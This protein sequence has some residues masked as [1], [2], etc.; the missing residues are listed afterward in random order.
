[1]K[2]KVL[3]NVDTLSAKKQI[4]ST[5]VSVGY[6]FV[7]ANTYDDIKFKCEL[8]KDNIIIYIHELDYIIYEEEMAYIKNLINRGIKVMLIIDKYDVS[9]I[10][11]ALSIGIYD[12][13]QIP[14]S[15]D[16]LSKKLK[17]IIS[18]KI[19][20]PESDKPLVHDASQ[21]KHNAQIIIN[22]IAL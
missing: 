6:D 10:D 22:D 5:I 12:I 9:I 4:L 11:E 19:S 2:Q 7:E 8:L 13:I 20:M 18:G 14:I 15:S 3:V 17:T 1:M 21:K 16:S